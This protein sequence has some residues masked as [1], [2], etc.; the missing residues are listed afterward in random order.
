MIVV[1][2]SLFVVATIQSSNK[3]DEGQPIN[4]KEVQQNGH[5]FDKRPEQNGGGANQIAK[6]VEEADADCDTPTLRNCCGRKHTG[7]HSS[8]EITAT[9]FNQSMCLTPTP[10]SVECGEAGTKSKRKNVKSNSY[11]HVDS[12]SPGSEFFDDDVD[13]RSTLGAALQTPLEPGVG[14]ELFLLSLTLSLY[15]SLYLSHNCLN[16]G[17][18]RFWFLQLFCPSFS[19]SSPSLYLGIC[20]EIWLASPRMRSITICVC[21]NTLFLL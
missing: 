8:P 4:Q 21:V 7:R 13:D 11:E 20:L 16:F 9:A 15:L 14:L 5:T 17:F 12:T 6:A 10:P 18:N 3:R 1:S 19:H 2:S